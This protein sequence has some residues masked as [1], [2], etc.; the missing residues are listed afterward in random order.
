[1]PA[2]TRNRD[3]TGASDPQRWLLG[4]ATWALLLLPAALLYARA[5]GDAVLTLIALLFLA[6]AAT[7]G[8]WAWLRTP[9]TAVMALFWGWMVLC[10]ILAGGNPRSCRRWRRCASSSLSPRWKT[11]FSPTAGPAGDFGM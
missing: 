6:R 3:R 7:A 1:M 8:D 5:P 11:G 9:W 2:D 10:S 4:V